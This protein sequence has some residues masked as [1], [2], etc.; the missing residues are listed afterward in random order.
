MDLHINSRLIVPRIVNEC[1]SISCSSCGAV[2]EP[3]KKVV[4]YG[5]KDSLVSYILFVP[6]HRIVEVQIERVFEKS[7]ADT[8][9]IATSNPQ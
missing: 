9:T 6:E 7:L 5:K 4:R 8:V 3:L 1:Y 2:L